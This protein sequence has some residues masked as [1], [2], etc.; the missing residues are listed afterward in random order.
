MF[1]S[2]LWSP[3]L[4]GELS[5]GG[6]RERNRAVELKPAASLSDEGDTLCALFGV[7]FMVLEFVGCSGL[8]VLMDLST[9]RL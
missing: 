6:A 4:V 7:E 2:P 9:R 3:C 5:F 8:L 1:P